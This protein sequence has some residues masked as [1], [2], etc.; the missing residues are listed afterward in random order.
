MEKHQFVGIHFVASYMGCDNLKLVDVENLKN[1]MYLAV[2][3][4]GATI[5]G[6]IDHIFKSDNLSPIN[7][8]YTLVYILSES[9]ASIHT[10]PEVSS[11]FVDFFTCGTHCDHKQFDRLL[12]KYLNPSYSTSNVIRRDNNHI[13]T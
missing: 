12:Q 6:Q 9:H 13:I 1:A 5:L 10:Y 3:A 8:G 7:G 11:C 2:E 4:S